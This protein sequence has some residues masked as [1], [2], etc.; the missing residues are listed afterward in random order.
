MA[1]PRLF[2]VILVAFWLIIFSAGPLASGG[3]SWDFANGLGYAAY[4]GLVYL[5]LPLGARKDIS[6]HKLL[7][8]AVLVLTIFHAV[9][10][11]LSDN[12]AIEYIKTDAPPYM[13]IG[14]CSLLIVGWLTYVSVAPVRLKVHKTFKSFK[15]WHTRLATV[16][17]LGALYHIFASG[18]YLYTVY[19]VLLITLLTIVIKY[20]P[21]YVQRTNNPT[22][23]LTFVGA[24]F[25]AVS[26]F[27]LMKSLGS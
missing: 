16:S 12:A 23:A 24:S 7:G 27:V 9:W 19:Q 26:T 22:S 8:Y 21:S 18:L 4:F 3:R 25:V 11:L 2:L 1:R 13:W 6:Q 15:S 10:F 17:I 5:S 14:I 20:A